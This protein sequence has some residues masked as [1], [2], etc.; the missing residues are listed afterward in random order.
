[1]IKNPNKSQ[2]EIPTA[3]E[4]IAHKKKSSK[5]GQPRADHKHL[6]ETVLLHRL[7]HYTD[8]KSGRDATQLI[9]QPTKVCTICGRIST[10]DK[11]DSLYVEKSVWYPFVSH[12][13]ELSEKALALPKWYVDDYVGKFAKRMEDGNEQ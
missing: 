6:Y 8:H 12:V 4:E 3:P 2:R 9:V 5:K 11:D 7:Y 1:M 10:V 13:S